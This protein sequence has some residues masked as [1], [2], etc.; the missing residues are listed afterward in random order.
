MFS[1]SFVAANF[2]IAKKQ[3]KLLKSPVKINFF[4]L[5][6]VAEIV[7][8][9][10]ILTFW[11]STK[12]DLLV[13]SMKRRRL[14]HTGFLQMVGC[15]YLNCCSTSLMTD[16]QSRQRKVPLTS[17]GCTGWVRTTWPLMRSSVPMRAA[18]SSRILHSTEQMTLLISH[19]KSVITEAIYRHMYIII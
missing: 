12:R 2:K 19:A 7:Q 4:G 13:S 3:V 6:F 8:N 5:F 1:E 9:P 10:H 18:E 15:V 17:S 16:W 11:K 14:A